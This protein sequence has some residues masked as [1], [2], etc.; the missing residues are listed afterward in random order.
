M[1]KLPPGLY[2]QIV[3]RALA[4]SLAAIDASLTDV[5]PLRLDD[6]HDLIA[7]AVETRVRQA[8]KATGG[9]DEHARLSNQVALANRVLTLLAS[10][11]QSGTDDT[12]ELESPPRKLQAIREPVEPP[13][14]P[15]S[16]PRPRIPLRSSDLL[17][18]ARHD[19][20]LGPV[21]CREIASADRV[22][23]LCSFVKWSGLR[24]I[25]GALR[26]RLERRPGC[27][28]VLTTTYMA[29]TEA[30]ALD[31]LVEMG[32]QVRVSYDRSRT[33]LH[34]KA[35]LLHRESGFST[36][37]VGSSVPIRPDAHK[38][39]RPRRCS[40][41]RSTDAAMKRAAVLSRVSQLESRIGN[42]T[43]GLR[44]VLL[45]VKDDPR[46][47]PRVRGPPGHGPSGAQVR[48]VNAAAP[49][50]AGCT[51]RSWRRAEFRG[52]SNARAGRGAGDG[53]NPRR[54]S[55]RVT[56]M[57][58]FFP[59]RERGDEW[60]SELKVRRGCAGLDNDWLVFHSVVWQSKRGGR[61][62]DGEA[63]FILVHKQHGIVVLEVKGGRLSVVS[64]EWKST[65]RHGVVHDIKNPFVQAKDSKH[66]L[67]KF[68]QHAGAGLGSIP[69][70]HGVVFPDVSADEGIGMYGPRPLII[71]RADL[72]EIGVALTRLTQHWDQRASL[73][74]ESLNLFF[75][76]LAPTTTLK[77]RLRDRVADSQSQLLE[78]TKQQMQV[79]SVTRRLRRCE[80][81]GGAGT[82]KTVLAVERVR[83]L[84]AD[85]FATLLVCFNSPL[86]ERL[87]EELNGAGATVLTFHGLVMK[88]LHAVGRLP[89]SL[90]TQEWWE[91]EAAN[92][93][94]DCV[95]NPGCPS[96][97]AL[98][99]D[100]GQDFSPEW[101]P[102]LLMLLEDADDSP[103]YFFADSHQELYRTGARELA[104]WNQL[105]L[106]INCRNTLPIAERVAAVVDEP[107]TSSGAPGAKPTF[108]TAENEAEQIAIVEQLVYGMM[109][110]GH[111]RPDQIAVLCESRS[112]ADRLTERT[113]G[114]AAF[115]ELGKHG[116]VSETIHRFKG[117]ESDAI[118]VVFSGDS[119]PDQLQKLAYVAMSRA[120]AV[121]AVIGPKRLR[122]RLSWR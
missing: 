78:L 73:D 2:D 56:F 98:V 71:D 57:A 115:V 16:P 122:K 87:R 97:Q 61:Q 53:A 81:R 75:R 113:V 119:P 9:E 45:R 5:S 79:L 93:L 101:I 86:A 35:W 92:E 15:T 66:A 63:D 67:I 22:D 80:I 7:R 6:A 27:V 60:S 55:Y 8:L 102:A 109:E 96:F 21:L 120:R 14:E 32:A 28:R 85:G 62:A 43:L 26:A 48:H 105:V 83:R 100:E 24:Q 65:D 106:D 12:D 19:L 40:S 13:R 69:V 23:L 76:A 1:P 84:Q 54:K 89:P 90:P 118:V 68:L 31:A 121:L 111:L 3:D 10:D 49:N 46:R 52:P 94:A 103:A 70:C 82:G 18:N 11:A 117:L 91:L 4:D 116:V 30:R 58:R 99:V 51:G 88:A 44:C 114:D 64:G 50:D 20:S 74:G 37:F 77:T 110:D 39:T 47:S 59:N 17:I 41:S 104:G 112:F 42:R 38:K 107:P 72:A 34:A 25:E 95:G 108:M 36:A 33:R 29:A